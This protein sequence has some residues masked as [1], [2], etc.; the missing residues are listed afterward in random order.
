MKRLRVR[1]CQTKIT[2][3]EIQHA[4]QVY[5]ENNVSHEKRPKNNVSHENVIVKKN[6]HLADCTFENR[7]TLC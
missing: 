2:Q 4:T 3:F 5:H 1:T 7:D 6:K